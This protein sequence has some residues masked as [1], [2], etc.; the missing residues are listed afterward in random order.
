M[1]S[2]S[3]R[4]HGPEFELFC[5]LATYMSGWG[6]SAESHGRKPH[7]TPAPRNSSRSSCVRC[8]GWLRSF[9]TKNS[10]AD[11]LTRRAIE[12][13]A[14]ANKLWKHAD[15]RDIYENAYPKPQK[16]G[17][18]DQWKTHFNYNEAFKLDQLLNEPEPIWTHLR[19]VHDA[20]SAASTHGAAGDCLS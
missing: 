11:A 4:L 3:R 9:S 14:I 8:T 6:S 12:A 19:A 7:V 1:Q 10:D 2:L 15:L 16:D 17:H 5:E 20:A 18:R 13:T